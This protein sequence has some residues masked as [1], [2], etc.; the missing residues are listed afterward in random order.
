MDGRHAGHQLLL[1]LIHELPVDDAKEGVHH[2]EEDEL[3]T[4]ELVQGSLEVNLFP[5]VIFHVHTFAH[6]LFQNICKSQ[7]QRA[8]PVLTVIQD[9]S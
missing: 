1:R 9:V 7:T 5:S 8:L 3:P 2:Q 6:F 4:D